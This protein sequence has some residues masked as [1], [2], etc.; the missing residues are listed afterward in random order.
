ML[1][2]LY[3]C[4]CVCV[5]LCAYMYVCNV[6]SV[7]ECVGVNAG[8]RRGQRTASGV[9]PCL[10]LCLNQDLC[11]VL[12]QVNLWI[13]PHLC[14]DTQGFLPQHPAF[15]GSGN[16]CLCGKHF[17]HSAVSPAWSHSFTDDGVGGGR[18]WPCGYIT[19]FFS[20]ECPLTKGELGF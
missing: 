17:T 9:G 6:L 8:Q 2:C 5:C 12:A 7:C 16:S 15:R 3:L 19:T 13:H 4:L 18:Q 14:G 1:V 20:I 10:A 11:L